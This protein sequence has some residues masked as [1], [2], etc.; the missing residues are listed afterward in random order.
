MNDLPSIAA[1]VAAALGLCEHEGRWW[2][3]SEMIEDCEHCHYRTEVWYGHGLEKDG[4]NLTD[5]YWRCRLEDWLIAQRYSFAQHSFPTGIHDVW[6]PFEG[7]DG[8]AECPWPEAPA[9]LV[10]AV[11]RKMKP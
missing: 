2:E 6:Q 4:S 7:I 9:R 5:P 3:A 8:H 11:W 1:D 10:S